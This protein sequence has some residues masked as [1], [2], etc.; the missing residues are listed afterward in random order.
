MNVVYLLAAEEKDRNSLE[1]FRPNLES[2]GFSSVL[3]PFFDDLATRTAPLLSAFI[4]EARP[5]A[6]ISSTSM[7]SLLNVLRLRE[8]YVCVGVEHGTAPFKA[9]TYGEHLF[10]SDYYL[11]PTRLWHDRLARLYPQHRSRLRLGGYPRVEVL[12]DLRGQSLDVPAGLESWS[13]CEDRKLVIL[14]WGVDEWA[15]KTLP[16]RQNIAY[17]LHPADWRLRDVKLLDKAVIVISEPASAAFLLSRANVV[18]GD[19]SS[20]TLEAA[21]LGLQA[22]MVIDRSLYRL[23]CDMAPEFFDPTSSDYASVPH[24]DVQID[25]SCI[26][27]M[28]DLR[29]CLDNER[30]P[31]SS[32]RPQLR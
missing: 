14:S 31:S 32:V 11:A 30:R 4:E 10:A 5:V 12:R 13:Q 8:S 23:D 7:L 17:L 26:L 9:Y 1:A 16:D 19:F 21:A 3:I 2:R 25:R 28:E 29:R 6:V 22:H 20:L 15:L 24:V 27:K 18:F